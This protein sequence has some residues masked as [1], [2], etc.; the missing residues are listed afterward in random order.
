MKKRLLLVGWDSADWKIIRPLMARGEMPM[1]A[2]ILAEGAHGDLTTLEPSLSPMLW[3]TIATGRHAA[4]HGVHGFT[5]V[6]DGKIRPVSAATRACRAVWNIL[7]EKGLTTNLVGWF[8]TQGERDPNV[9]MVSNLYPHAPKKKIEQPSDWP[10]APPG[11]Y[12][13]DDLAAALDPLRVH[14]TA[15]DGNLMRMFIP[16]LGEI[17]QDKDKRPYMLAEHLAEAFSIQA[18]ATWL[19][20]RRPADLTMI[21]FRAIDEICHRFMPFHPPRMDGV[22]EEDFAFYHDVVNSAYRVHDLMLTRLVDLAGPDAAV[23]LISDHG[24]HSDH[25]RPT[26]VPNIPAGIVAWHRAQGIFAAAGPGL[27]PQADVFGARLPDIAPTILHYFGLPRA[28]DMEGRVLIDAFSSSDLVPEIATWE[29]SARPAFTAAVFDDKESEALIDHFVALGY[30]EAAAN[31]GGGAGARLTELTNRSQLA[32]ALMHSGRDEE[33][34]PLLEELFA[35]L[36]NRPDL[37]QRLATCQLRLEL[38]AEADETITLVARHFKDE[39]TVRLIR[40]HIAQQRGDTVAALDLLEQVKANRPD[41]IGL[42][43]QF[44]RALLDA[45]RWSDAEAEARAVVERD[46][47]DATSWTILARSLLHQ[48]QNEEAAEAAL[49][50]IDLEFNRPFAHLVLGAALARLGKFPEATTAFTNCLKLNPGMIQACRMLAHS[51]R[52]QGLRDEAETAMNQARFMRIQRNHGQKDRHARV[53]AAAGQRADQRRAAREALDRALG[54]PL[55]LVVVT[56]LPRSGTSLMMQMLDAGGLPPLTDGRRE[57]NED[58]PRGYYEWEDIKKLPGNPALINA[59]KDKAVKI[60]TPLLPAL[61]LR[62]RYKLLYMRRPIAEIVSSQLKMLE[63]SGHA[64][65]L[66]AETLTRQLQAHAIK[67]RKMLQQNKQ[68]ELLVIDYPALI[69]DPAAV[70][71]KVREFIGAEKLPGGVDAM[72]AVVDGGLY[73]NRSKVEG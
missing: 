58:N 70:A 26:F 35:S 51:L 14:P 64:T 42:R 19:M 1:L 9:R 48:R 8:A 47:D 12:F 7:S 44:A 45:R 37:G 49:T 33:A 13:P 5:E 59:A 28:R 69:A 2:K 27:R 21:Y 20:A 55:D 63:R 18:A 60:V 43:Q 11:T 17:D 25:L 10:P 71:G 68:V 4:E 66:S 24:F 57:A 39:D 16:R 3:T 34:L 40:A 30:M 62:H 36:P 46:P 23:I 61:P 72:A 15:L 67:T 6:R 53:H 41:A 65:G 22:K 29:T 54:D 50:A 38:F 52:R 31:A 56:G 73:R 32:I